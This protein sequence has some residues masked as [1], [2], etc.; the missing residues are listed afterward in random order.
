MFL[1]TGRILFIYDNEQTRI[2]RTKRTQE[3]QGEGKNLQIVTEA[4]IKTIK[5]YVK[6]HCLHGIFY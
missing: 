4:K 2:K 6:L 1:Q 3:I 5:K